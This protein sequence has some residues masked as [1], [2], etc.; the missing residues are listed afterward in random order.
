MGTRLREALATLTDPVAAQFAPRVRQLAPPPHAAFTGSDLYAVQTVAADRLVETLAGTLPS[1]DQA[2]AARIRDRERRAA[3]VVG[4][5][6]LAAF[7]CQPSTGPPTPSWSVSYAG[8][9]VVLA[10]APTA[11]SVGVDVERFRTLPEPCALA[12]AA[13]WGA[14][15]VAAIGQSHAS[16]SVFLR[17][18]TLK[19]ALSKAAGTGIGSQAWHVVLDPVVEVQTAHVGHAAFAVGSVPTLRDHHVALAARL[20]CA[21]SA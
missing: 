5:A 21:A 3:F 13:G 12:Q 9:L 17:L 7:G 8:G 15:E 14:A 1:I 10:V 4:R 6:L 11:P 18:W 20:A 2:R 19:E 16:A